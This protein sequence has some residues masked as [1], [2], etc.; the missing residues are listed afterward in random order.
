MDLL[1][2][3]PY[4]TLCM[5]LNKL[6]MTV[7]FVL[8]LTGLGAV[9]FYVYFDVLCLLGHDK[10][11]CFHTNCSF[12]I[13]GYH[14]HEVCCVLLDTV[15]CS[16]VVSC[17]VVWLYL[18]FNAGG[19]EAK[20]WCTGKDVRLRIKFHNKLNVTISSLFSR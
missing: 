5:L 18:P 20:I 13:D 3:L 1:E 16:S 10:L 8:I 9:V 14:D 4:S 7:S 12:W 15:E 17:S 2:L 11:H 19:T 6:E